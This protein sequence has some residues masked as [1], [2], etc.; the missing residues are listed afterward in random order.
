MKTLFWDFDGTLTETRP[1]WGPAVYEA[2]KSE[3]PDSPA[4]F[5]WIRS[6]LL[7]GFPWHDFAND[8]TRL[9]GDDFWEFVFEKFRRLYESCGVGTEQ[10]DRISR[11][12]RERI[13]D[14]GNYRVC[15]DAMATLDHCSGL[16]YRNFLLSN[17]Y[18]ELDRVVKELGLADHFDGFTIS[19]QV[20]YDKPRIEIF[21][22][23]LKLSGNPEVAY[24]I[25]DNPIADIQGARQAGMKTI[26]VHHAPDGIADFCFQTLAEIPAVLP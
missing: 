26:L 1:H 4:S 5:D 19:G 14:S 25:G 8:N 2:L 11:S 6:H 15:P 24:M 16:G 20:G 13:L 12:V 9:V 21:R 22:I 3:C 17:N 10:A 18:P 7:Y 23:A